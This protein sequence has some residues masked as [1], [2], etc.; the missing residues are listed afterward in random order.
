VRA[1]DAAG[2]TSDF[3]P[4]VTVTTPSGGACSV[5]L[6]LQNAWS[7]GYVMQPNTVTNTGSSALTGWTIT[8]TL[9]AGHTI[10]NSWNA[11][12]TVIGQSVTARGISGQNATLAPGISTTWGFQVSRPDGN[13]AAPTGPTCTS[14]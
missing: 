9:P 7:N 12:V 10:T 11:T 5:T 2:N 13:T 4:T 1:R 6:T 8:F 3:S 14:P